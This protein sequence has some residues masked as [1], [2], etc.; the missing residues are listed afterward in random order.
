MNYLAQG[1]SDGFR[2]GADA[3][4]QRLRRQFELDEAAKR[5]D[6]EKQLQADRITADAKRQFSDQ[7]H[8]VGMQGRSLLAD[9]NKT[10]ATQ[11]FQADEAEK[12]RGFH[13]SESQLD[14]DARKLSQQAQLDQ[15]AEQFN[16]NNALHYA[17][18]GLTASSRERAQDWKEDADNPYNTIR[19]AQAAKLKADMDMSLPPVGGQFT[20]KTA[21][22]I[23]PPPAAIDYLKKNPEM[24]AQFESKYG[25][26][27]ASNYLR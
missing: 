25:P 13:R 12:G 5:R 26:G 18:L 20:P 1:L 22:K 9:A 7:E 10:N 8:Q 11:K 23:T 15:A 19:D 3:N 6:L 14:R 21:P 16:R 24:R 2:I 27:S 4:Q 17:N